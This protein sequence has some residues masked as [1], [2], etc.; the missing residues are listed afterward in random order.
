MNV[1]VMQLGGKKSARRQGKKKKTTHQKQPFRNIH[2][3]EN[4]VKFTLGR[5]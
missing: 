1:R 4:A 3:V 2:S 5:I